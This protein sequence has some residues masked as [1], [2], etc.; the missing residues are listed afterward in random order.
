MSGLLHSL[1]TQLFRNNFDV[2]I[3]IAGDRSSA[4]AARFIWEKGTPARLTSS[5]YTVFVPD[6]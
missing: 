4:Y 5:S 3:E 1:N 2:S 6:T